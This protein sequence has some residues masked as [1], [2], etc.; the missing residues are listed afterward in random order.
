MTVTRKQRL[1]QQQAFEDA[2][3]LAPDR[4]QAV[5]SFDDG[6]RIVHLATAGDLRREGILMRN[7]LAK[8]AGDTLVSERRGVLILGPLADC[9]PAP[10][11]EPCTP[12][13]RGRHVGAQLL[14]LRDAQN[15][16]HLTFWAKDGSH[17][18]SALGYRNAQPK[19]S[20][21]ERLAQWAEAAEIETFNDEDDHGLHK[22]D[23]RHDAFGLVLQVR[24][25]RMIASCAYPK[26]WLEGTKRGD[27]RDKYHASAVKGFTA[28]VDHAIV[29]EAAVRQMNALIARDRQWL[30]DARYLLAGK[31]QPL[32]DEQRERILSRVGPAAR[33]LAE[34]RRDRRRWVRLRTLMLRELD[35]WEFGLDWAPL[36]H[37]N[38]HR[39]A[40]TRQRST[41]RRR[42]MLAGG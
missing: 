40:R 36:Y 38:R 8:Y 17:A 31:G 10:A 16:P 30:R 1:A 34:G 13:L 29:A 14:S 21:R 15:L 26:P 27:A 4:V 24:L 7:C 18:C 12:E 25:D 2:G 3:K 28:I 22:F 35:R 41:N 33:R 23:A 11:I 20:Y 9:D 39:S 6:W 32:T 19:E 42:R 37:M 5:H